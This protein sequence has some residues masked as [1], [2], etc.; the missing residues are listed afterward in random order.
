MDWGQVA[1]WTEIVSRLMSAIATCQ[2]RA[3]TTLRDVGEVA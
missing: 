1:R 2:L 3:S